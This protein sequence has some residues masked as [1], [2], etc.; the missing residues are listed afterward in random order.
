MIHITFFEIGSEK[1][2]LENNQGLT[3]T[4]ETLKMLEPLKNK[5]FA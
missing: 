3:Q 1:S 5:T 2:I 4:K